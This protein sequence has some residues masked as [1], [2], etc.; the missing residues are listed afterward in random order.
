MTY[1]LIVRGGTAIV[2]FPMTSLPGLLSNSSVCALASVVIIGII[3]IV[4][5]FHMSLSQVVCR[6]RQRETSHSHLHWLCIAFDCNFTKQT[7]ARDLNSVQ[8]S[9]GSGH[10]FTGHPLQPIPVT[11]LHHNCNTDSNAHIGWQRAPHHAPN[12][13][14]WNHYNSKSKF[15]YSIGHNMGII[16]AHCTLSSPHSPDSPGHLTHLTCLASA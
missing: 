5:C 8:L 1:F 16:W 9:R 3:A 13:N 12:C 14:Q 2:V 6:E 15:Q 10:A 4:D 11:T 7:N